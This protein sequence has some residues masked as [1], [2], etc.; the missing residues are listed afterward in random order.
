MSIQTHFNPS[1]LFHVVTDDGGVTDLG[2]EL[3]RRG[4]ASTIRRGGGV[5]ATS[6]MF[7]MAPGRFQ[8]NNEEEEELGEAGE[9]GDLL[10]DELGANAEKFLG[11]LRAE[12]FSPSGTK[13]IEKIA[14]R[15]MKQSKQHSEDKDPGFHARCSVASR[16]TRSMLTGTPHPCIHVGANRSMRDTRQVRRSARSESGRPTEPSIIVGLPPGEWRIT[17]SW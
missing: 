13:T 6:G 3:G 1:I 7:R 12:K 10:R 4:K 17:A 8:G 15:L 11:W 2:A 14:R 9:M 5:V 16:S